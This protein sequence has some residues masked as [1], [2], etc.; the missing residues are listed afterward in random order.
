VCSG[1]EVAIVDYM[2]L[3]IFYIEPAFLLSNIENVNLTV[4]CF[5]YGLFLAGCRLCIH[6]LYYEELK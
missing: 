1:L 3:Y 4:L 6:A 2:Y 5:M